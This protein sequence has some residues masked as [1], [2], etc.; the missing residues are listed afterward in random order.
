M[1]CVVSGS[2]ETASIQ[3]SLGRIQFYY[4]GLHFPFLLIPLLPVSCP[5]LSHW[6]ILQPR[7]TKLLSPP[8]CRQEGSWHWSLFCPQMVAVMD[9]LLW[10]SRAVSMSESLSRLHPVSSPLHFRSGHCTRTTLGAALKP[11]CYPMVMG[12]CSCGCAPWMFAYFQPLLPLFLQSR[13]L[14][15]HSWLHFLL[16]WL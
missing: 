12:S 8:G 4:S 15:A 10:V 7:G 1:H 11:L 3:K 14:D 5:L 2:V 13:W 16:E 9:L 6:V